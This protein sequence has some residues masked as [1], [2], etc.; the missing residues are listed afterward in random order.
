MKEWK[1][2]EEMLKRTVTPMSLIMRFFVT[3]IFRRS[4]A[5]HSGMDSGADTT[6]R[7]RT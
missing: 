6:G 4:S 3:R 5:K 7:C 2:R 1:R